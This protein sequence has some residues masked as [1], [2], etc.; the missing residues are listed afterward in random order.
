LPK[1]K[2]RRQITGVLLVVLILVVVNSQP[3]RELISLPHEVRLIEG[4]PLQLNLH[5]P[6]LYV[7][8]DREGIISLGGEVKERGKWKVLGG[9]PIS[10]EPLQLGEVNLELKFFGLI[11]WRKVNVDVLPEIRLVPGGQS[12]GVLL[13]TNGII[14]TALG[15]VVDPAG[16][17]H[18]PAVEAGVEVGDV[19][20]KVNDREV[21]SDE[22]MAFVINEAGQ[23]G[24]PVVLEIKRQGRIIYK[25]VK[26]VFCRDT[27]RFRIGLFVKDGTAG[28]G[29]LTFY[30]P[31]TMIYG[32]LGHVITDAESNQR[33]EVREGN[34][35]L[36]R[37]TSIEKAKGGHPGEKIGVF[38]DQALAGKIYSNTDFGI[39]GQLL[40]PPANGMTESL[41]IALIGQV[42]PGPAEILTVIEGDKVE[43]FSVEIQRI[44]PQDAPETKGM[45]IRITDPRLLARTGGIVQG[46]SGSPI[47][48]DGRLVGAVTHVFVND[49]TR[50]YGVFIE[51]MVWQSGLLKPTGVRCQPGSFFVVG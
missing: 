47:L 49:P 13:K 32:A 37:I 19:I 31:K 10:L 38:D 42:H 18:Y 8:P 15:K 27:G 23:K 36:A 7:R 48:Q 14:V 39:F 40:A 24:L 46:M 26:A 29:T 12:I 21:K 41:P 9:A 1:E 20:L 3:Y 5:L 50:G 6:Y 4:Q 16:G 44:F 11:P 22:E 34:I 25:T 51:W 45:I 30:D 17:E 35:V 28:V 43:H 2:K 33:L